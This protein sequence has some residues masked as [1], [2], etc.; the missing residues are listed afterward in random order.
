MSIVYSPS[1][2]G[3]FAEG[4][5]DPL[6]ADGIPVDAATHAYLLQRQAEGMHIE[7]GP[8]GRPVAVVP[9]EPT[10]AEQ[11]HH[12]NIAVQIHLNKVAQSLG[13]DSIDR[14]I[15]YAEDPAVPAW[16]AEGQALRAWRSAVWLAAFDAMKT[17]P[18]PTQ[19]ALLATLPRPATP[20]VPA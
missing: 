6:P 17:R 4:I 11:L 10:E 9:P 8:D 2:R 1:A 3:F 5:H 15:S 14:A 16:Q 20:K 12:L 13:Y 7:P 18:L 19:A